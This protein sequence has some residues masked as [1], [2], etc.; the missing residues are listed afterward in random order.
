MIVSESKTAVSTSTTVVSASETSVLDAETAVSASETVVL[1]AEAAD[2]ASEAAILDA[3]HGPWGVRTGTKT[4]GYAKICR[5]FFCL[6]STLQVRCSSKFFSFCVV[7]F[8]LG[9][10]ASQSQVHLGLLRLTVRENV[11]T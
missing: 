6:A 10:L 4:N 11:K 8:R 2:S 1:D 7:S 5:K 9:C 3:E